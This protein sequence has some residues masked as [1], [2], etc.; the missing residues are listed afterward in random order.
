MTFW[1]LFEY[2]FSKFRRIIEYVYFLFNEEK[3]GRQKIDTTCPCPLLESVHT[4]NGVLVD[5]FFVTF[6]LL[7]AEVS[8]KSS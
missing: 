6:Q 4:K 1:S 5:K 7:S 8:L 3:K 2:F